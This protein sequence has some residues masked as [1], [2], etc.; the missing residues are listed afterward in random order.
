MGEISYDDFKKLE[1]C[2]GKVK[3]VERIPNTDKLYK[4]KVDVGKE[5]PIQIV[6]SL[7]DYYSEEEL[8]GKKIIVLL[9]LKPSEFRGEISQGMLLCAE[10]KDHS[11]CVLLTVDKDIEPGTPVT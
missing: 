1:M 8:K 7:V 5:Q 10:T 11:K 2:V 9:N 6:T 3:E 4:L